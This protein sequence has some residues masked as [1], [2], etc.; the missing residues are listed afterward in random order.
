LSLLTSVAAAAVFAGAA[1]AQT[2][3]PS[4]QADGQSQA[5]TVQEVVVT[6][7]KRKENLQKVP[8][9]VT[10]VNSEALAKA[11]VSGFSDLTKF[12]PSMTVSAGD[13]PANSAIIIRG[14]GTFAYSIAAEPSVLVVI[15]DVAVGYQA[16][17]FTDLVDIDRV[18]VLSGPQ[19]TLYG[20]SASAGLVAV[21]TQAPSSTFTYAAPPTSS[22]PTTT[23][24]ARPSTSL[25][26]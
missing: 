16:Q 22:S 11:N 7:Q 5:Q 1:A 19:S 10:V 8:L 14:V 21:T 15:D 24:S 6:A 25:A 9:S 17:A 13:Q 4:A 23:S 12:T 3:P 2:A 20:K 26:R 18:E